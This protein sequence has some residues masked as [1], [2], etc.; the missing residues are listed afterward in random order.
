MKRCVTSLTF[1]EGRDIAIVEA[2]LSTQALPAIGADEPAPAA[3][4]LEATAIRLHAWPPSL[5]DTRLRPSFSHSSSAVQ[6]GS[7]VLAAACPL[8]GRYVQRNHTA[9]YCCGSVHVNWS[10]LDAKQRTGHRRSDRFGFWTPGPR[11]EPML[12]L[13]LVE[14]SS[15]RRVPTTWTLWAINLREGRTTTQRV[16]EQTRGSR[17]RPSTAV[18][19]TAGREKGGRG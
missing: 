5:D 3:P 12:I 14:S 10:N 8:P 17:P 2:A 7:A 11:V 19:V 15:G 16:E 6:R 13:P 4:L 9:R 18:V 1:T